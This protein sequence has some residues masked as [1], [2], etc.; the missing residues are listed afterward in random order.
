MRNRNYYKRLI[1]SLEFGGHKELEYKEQ[2]IKNESNICTI[3]MNDY[4]A[5]YNPCNLYKLIIII[6]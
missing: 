5:M 3:T 6:I 2:T 1:I 4:V